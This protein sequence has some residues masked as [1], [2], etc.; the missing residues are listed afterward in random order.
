MYNIDT[1]H[2]YRRDFMNSKHFKPYQI[3]IVKILLKKA[4]CKEIYYYEK[5]AK[6][7]KISQPELWKALGTI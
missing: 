4:L 7:I 6:E 3:E 1:S 5:L 2:N